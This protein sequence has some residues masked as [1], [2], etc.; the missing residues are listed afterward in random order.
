M[1]EHARVVIVGGGM[2][3][4]GLL[5]HLAEE[6]WTDIVLLEK[7]ELTS[8]STWHAAGQCPHF[9]GSLS[10]AHIHFYGTQL[11]P[12]LGEM[13]GQSAG[14]H[15]CG[16][17]RLALTDEE[18]D[19]F[20]YV[21]G[22]AKLVGYEAHLIPPEE[23]RRHHPFL[24]TFGVKLGFL[25]VSDG[26]VDPSSAANALAIAARR[27]GATIEKRTRVTNIER[28]PSGE[29]RVVTDRGSIT[30]EHVVNAAGS[31]APQVGAW[32][33]LRVPCVNMLHHYIVTEPL[34]EVKALDREL[35]VVRDPY[36]HCYLRQEQKGLLIG[37]YEQ[38]GA[39][40]VFDDGV[41]WEF[42]SELLPPELDRLT[43][44]LERAAER[45]P[46]FGR[47]GIRR[48]VSGAITH[49]PDS[50]P[51]LGPAPR[52][53]NYWM[54]CGSSIGI[55]Q[56]PGCGR[57]L[58]QLMV[59]GEA[60]IDML[61]FD[62]RRF[63]DW[64]D[65]DYVR[66]TAVHDYEHMYYCHKPG[67]F[68]DVGR[69][70]RIS[71]LYRRLGGKGAVWAV[72]GGWERPKWFAPPGVEERY[73]FRR[74]NAFEHVGREAL[75]VRERVGVMDLSS[76][77]KF[78][79]RGPDAAALLDRLVANRLPRRD[80]GIVLAHFLDEAGR[81]MGEVTITRLAPD[82]FY[83]LSGA[84]SELRD[85][86][87]LRQ[88]VRERERVE[89]ENLSDAFGMLVVAGP[90]AREV[91]QPLTPTSLAN[92]DF[93]W[94]T[95]REIELAGVR[96][97]ALRVNY[98]GELGFELHCPMAD[99]ERVYD[100]VVAEGEK[101]GIADFGAYAMNSL[102]LEKAY[103]GFGQE[104]TNEVTMFEAAMER[105]LALDKGEFVGREATL[106]ARERGPRFLLAYLEVD[107][108]D[109]DCLGNEPVFAD[110]RRVG[111]TTSGGYGFAVGKSLAFAYVEPPLAAPGTPL[112]VE[113]LGD[114]RPARVLAEPAWDPANERLRA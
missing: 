70:K 81:M 69:P 86:D 14:W 16:G 42:E 28:L 29:W 85:L 106:R 39:R 96:L 108:A 10:M 114:R 61:D 37:P 43:P 77:A 64:C 80:G 47:A 31:Y 91:L 111:V 53:R 21:H 8:G 27:R 51:L 99:L 113:I 66:K 11:Y 68:F 103:R 63:G 107:A 60:E 112:G 95:G 79:V 49:T 75:A 19:W 62:P 71:T 94:L 72:A 102:R 35:P 73:G 84:A 1:R 89:I 41:P 92:A 88:G 104:L 25:T 15:G 98:V 38:E 93:R 32:T 18:V 48:I 20:R 83:V 56:G 90:R 22:I 109:A 105:F 65:E 7:G 100:A 74:T 2:M 12:K 44:W 46:L 40:T 87:R 76:F 58:A 33:G 13:T 36:S 101:H 30:C 59:H 4:I 24:E 110:G 67:E 6:G 82:H 54:A 5:Y 97:R 34:E 3:G 50:Y 45:L 26:H 55:A 9:V 57:Y 52:L 23:I 17:I 78:D